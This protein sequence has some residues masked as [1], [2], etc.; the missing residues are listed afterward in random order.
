MLADKLRAGAGKPAPTF[1]SSASADSGGTSV[2]SLNINKPA[3]TIDNDLMLLV[4]VA[5]AGAGGG[6]YTLPA[7]W[8]EV[9][10]SGSNDAMVV[11]YKT[12]SSEGSSYTIN[13]SNTHPLSGHII[14]Y[15]SAEWEATGTGNR[16]NNTLPLSGI[17]V[18]TSNSVVIAALGTREPSTSFS[19]ANFSLVVGDS[20]ANGP[21]VAFHSYTNPP[22]GSLATQTFTASPPSSLRGILVLIK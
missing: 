9:Y 19:S 2:T 21:S 17:T 12:A 11:G 8:T 20:D 14:T 3:G 22:I 18:S 1:I 16:Q 4:V 10:D 6:N 15:R 5:D 13:Y 7:G